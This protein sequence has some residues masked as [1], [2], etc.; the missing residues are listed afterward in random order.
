MTA[1]YFYFFVTFGLV[2]P[3]L[4]PVLLDLG[5]EKQTIGLLLGGFYIMNTVAPI[6]GGR[7]SDRYTSAD[8]MLRFCAG[9][10]FAAAL[11]MIFFQGSLLPLLLLMFVAFRAP[12][13]PL[14][15]A[16]AMQVADNRAG[17]YARMRLMG[18]VGFAVAVTGYGYIADAWDYGSF[19]T[20][21]AVVCAVFYF[22][23][24]FLPAEDKSGQTRETHIF[25]RSLNRSWW[26]WLLAMLF[27]SFCFG[28]YNYGFNLL[29]EEAGV[30]TKHTGW[31]WNIGIAVEVAVFWC[32]DWFFKRWT[33]RQL[34]FVA[35]WA[36]LLRWGLTGLFPVPGI[37]LLGQSLHGFGFAM[38]YAAA[39][40]EIAGYAGK[41]NRASFQGLFSTVAG[42]IAG[43]LGSISAGWLHQ[44]MPF[45]DVLLWILPVQVMA[46][47]LYSLT[48][49]KPKPV[50]DGGPQGALPAVS[51]A[52]IGSHR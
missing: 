44:R 9:G 27:H 3:F 37:I 4:S 38:F 5:Y 12:V 2:L 39:L 29:L 25:W 8:R 51:A 28:P 30:A 35:L 11:L 52:D 45:A 1:S 32:S 20:V 43:V 49:L 23:G 22:N 41:G 17:P 21:L 34:M 6:L 33:P 19:F 36:N 15:D 42:G 18:S 48:R 10:M 26:L 50:D 16:L 40:Q 24:F 14:Q 47:V 7:I 46:I 13:I 31:Y